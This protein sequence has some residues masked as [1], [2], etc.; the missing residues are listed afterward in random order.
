M[1]DQRNVPDDADI[2]QFRKAHI[3][4]KTASNHFHARFQA[5]VSSNT[6]CASDLEELARDLMN[7]FDNFIAC[8]KVFTGLK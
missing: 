4:W 3:D 5:I 8:S 1:L 6:G 7:K 2:D